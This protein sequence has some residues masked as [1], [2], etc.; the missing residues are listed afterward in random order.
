MMGARVPEDNR[1]IDQICSHISCYDQLCHWHKIT[2]LWLQQF[3]FTYIPN[4]MGMHGTSLLTDLHFYIYTHYLRIFPFFLQY[5]N[6]EKILSMPSFRREVKPFAPC[7]KFV[8]CKRSLNGVKKGVISAKLP[9]HS[10][11]QFHHSLLGVPT[12]MG[13]WRHLAAKVGTS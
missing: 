12:L 13:T 7:R 6:T 2:I 5:L 3:C 9:H 1:T 4:S 11:P 10:R 8:A